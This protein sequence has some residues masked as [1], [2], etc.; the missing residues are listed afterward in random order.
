MIDSDLAPFHEAQG[1]VMHQVTE[2]II[3]GRKRTHWMWFIFPQL[4]G[5]G[6]SL[7]SQR[8]AI[9]NVEEAR[10]YLA[11]PVLGGRLRRHV[12]LMLRHTDKSALDILGSPDDLKFHSCLTLFSEAASEPSDRDL[13]EQGLDH[14]YEGRPDPITQRML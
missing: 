13:F 14:F 10:R 12:Q 8:Y 4:A 11:D 5:L 1:P 7:T 6:S 9:K 2:E 3:A